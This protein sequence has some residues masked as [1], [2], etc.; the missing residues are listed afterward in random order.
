M[1]TS[2]QLAGKRV[3]LGV[4]A[5]IAAYKA[6]EIASALVKEGVEVFPILTRDATRFIGAPTLH[7][8]TGHPCPVDVFDEPYPGQIAHIYL[9]QNCDLF[10]IAPASMD[11]IARL[12]H[13]LASDMLT[14]SALAAKAPLLVAPAMNSAMWENPA[15]QTNIETLRRYGYHFVEPAT[16]RLACRTEGIGKLADVQDILTAIRSHLTRTSSLAGKRILITAGPTR[17]PL[18]PVRFISN[19]SSGKMGYALAGAAAARG[20]TVT[21]VSGPVALP[22]PPNVDVIYVE[23]ASEMQTAVLGVAGSADVII[24]SAAIADYAPA[25]IAAQK[26]KKSTAP[27]SLTLAPTVDFSVILGQ[28]KRS[29]QILIGFAAETENLIE[30]AQ[31]KLERK[32]LD[33]IVANDVT[34]EGAGFDVDT[35]IVT[36]ISRDQLVNL[37]LMSK[38]EV[39]EQILDLIPS[40]QSP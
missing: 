15:T 29:D 6:A 34:K 13:G 7:A 12:A 5:S 4:S 37:P 21:L 22:P 18:D 14:A 30:G 2:S 27:M 8:L 20:A 35:N 28:Q 17:E 23:T 32:N 40:H 33:W 39:A 19:R 38:R 36:L 9:A 24:Q 31:R 10:V 1:E 3:V 25:E 26:V 16:G 11:V